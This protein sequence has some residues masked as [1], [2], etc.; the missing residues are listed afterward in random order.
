MNYPKVIVKWLVPMGIIDLYRKNRTATARKKLV[1]E[2]L[3][4]ITTYLKTHPVRKLNLGCGTNILEGW[5]NTD[6]CLTGKVVLLDCC[7]PFPIDNNQFDYIYSEH[8]IE[9]INYLTGLQMLKECCRVLKPGGKIRIATPDLDKILQLHHPQKTALQHKYIHWSIDTWLPNLGYY[10]DELVINRIFYD[11]EHR[12]IYNQKT[13]KHS[14]ECSGFT[15]IF[16]C[17]INESKDP[18]FRGIEQHG[19]VI[20][21]EFNRL[22]TLILEGQKAL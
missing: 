16:S 7:L 13:L 6:I 4:D 18:V 2:Q 14:L 10:A 5:L 8:L 3:N 11:W 19:N 22:E 15:N 21:D 20:P 9:H 1:E 12:F 17:N